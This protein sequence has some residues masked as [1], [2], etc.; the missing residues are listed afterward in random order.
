[1]YEHV[2]STV[3]GKNEAA[4]SWHSSVVPRSLPSEAPVAEASEEQDAAAGGGVA[5]PALKATLSFPF[6]NQG[7]VSLFKEIQSKKLYSA[8][9][10]S[11]RF[12][13]S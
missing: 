9:F 2:K 8:V 12:Q 1:M 7:K 4:P 5:P 3:W 13:F 10:T 6:T 11:G